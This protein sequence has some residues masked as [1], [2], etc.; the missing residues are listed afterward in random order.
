MSEFQKHPLSK[1][2]KIYLELVKHL[3]K[4]APY[5]ITETEAHE[6]ARNLIGLCKTLIEI[7]MQLNKEKSCQE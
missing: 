1:A 2:D 7:Q 3:Q 5:A 4:T 6:A